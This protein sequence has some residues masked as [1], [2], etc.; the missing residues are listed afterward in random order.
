MCVCVF[1]RVVAGGY[2]LRELFFGGH[3]DFSGSDVASEVVA[4][5][6]RTPNTLHPPVRGKAFGIPAVTGIVGHLVAHV[7]TKPQLRRVNSDSSQEQV[8]T[9]YE[10]AESLVCHQPL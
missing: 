10:V 5:P 6:V 9:T 3:V 1:V 2:G 4:G 8:N 7:L